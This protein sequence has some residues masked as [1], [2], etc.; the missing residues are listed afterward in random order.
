MAARGGIGTSVV[1]DA[2]RCQLGEED[3]KGDIILE[4][5]AMLMICGNFLKSGI[6][7][8]WMIIQDS[9]DIEIEVD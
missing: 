9:I 5:E 7:A 4:K 1:A 6:V 8:V 3:P 2:R